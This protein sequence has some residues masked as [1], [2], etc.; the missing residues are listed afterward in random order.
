MSTE[1]NGL[2]SPKEKLMKKLICG[3]LA[4]LF[5]VTSISAIACTAADKAKDGSQVNTPPRTKS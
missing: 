3:L 1:S 2:S 4:A 5:A